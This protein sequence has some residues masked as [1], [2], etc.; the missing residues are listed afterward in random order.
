MTDLRNHGHSPHNEKFDLPELA[1]DVAQLF[2]DETLESAFLLGHSL[3]GKT[4]MVFSYKYTQLL[5]GLVVI[6]MAPRAYPVHHRPV[7]DALKKVPLSSL[8]SRKDA[9]EILN[10][11]LHDQVMVQF[12]MKGLYRKDAEHFGWRFNVDAINRQIE[13]IGKATYPDSPIAVP[14]LFIRGEKS[15]YI[16]VDDEKDIKSNFSNVETLIAPGAGHWVHADNPS[17]LLEV[18]TDFFSKNA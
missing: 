11:N 10:Q 17:W 5:K 6:D 2:S 13:N 8:Q 7:L 1:D 9:E 14:A 18:V 16:T 4:A 12:L 3:G 15:D